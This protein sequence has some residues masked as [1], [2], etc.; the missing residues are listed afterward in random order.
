MRKGFI[1]NFDLCVDC[2]ACSASCLLENR[3]SESARTI[4]TYN[5]E[6]ISVLPITHLSLAC[7]HC[8]KP[9]C[10]Y[11]CP[12][13]AFAKDALTSA[14]IIDSEKCIG[15]RY[16]IWNCPYDAPKLNLH[17]GVIVKCDFC[18]SRIQEGDEPACTA[19][20]PTGSLRFGE[21]PEIAGNDVLNWFPEKDIN[22][23][24]KINGT[25]DQFPLR[26]FPETG[27][28]IQRNNPLSEEKSISCEWSLILFSFLIVLS[29]SFNISNLLG[30]RSIDPIS[31]IVVLVLA[32]IFSIFHLRKK[33][34]ACKAILNY[35]NS[36]L[37]REIILFIIYSAISFVAL[38][39]D[40][41]WLQLVSVLIGL[42]LLIAID[43]VYTFADGSTL[44]K[45][46][47]GQTFLTGLLISSYLI[48]AVYPFIF[49]A[50]VKILFNLY[51]L[52]KKRPINLFFNLRIFRMAFL[53][54]ISLSMISGNATNDTIKYII[55]L[56]GE[57]ADRIL[58]YADFEPVNIKSEIN[59]FLILSYHEKEGDK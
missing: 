9:A 18:H 31:S 36:P 33:V 56:S 53:L 7:N 11:G 20:C 38:V 50:S 10:L 25:R 17:S 1:I 45:F 27:M 37:S 41:H 51:Y 5:T 34:K 26:I 13:G 12:T 55:F 39:T 2:K 28:E 3:W 54:I 4:Y 6:S 23:G 40:H 32:G 42:L 16:C 52:I 35:K 57:F 44:M 21:I 22:P 59:K 49:I 43:N 58:Y 19:A 14:I 29:A 30:G 46:H 15:C 48:N 8:K 24:I 47:S